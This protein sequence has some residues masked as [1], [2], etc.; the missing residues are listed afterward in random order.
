MIQNKFNDVTL[1]TVMY[2][3]NFIIENFLRN[4]FFFKKILILDN[5][6]S[7]KNKIKIN[8]KFKNVKYFISKN[9][10]G[11]ARGNNFLL[12][13]VTT[14]YVFIAT[15][16]L[17]IDKKN[18]EILYDSKK[19]IKSFG[20][21]APYNIEKSYIKIK[22]KKTN[23][24]KNIFET[25]RPDGFAL[26]IDMSN[27]RKVKFFDE[28]FF[29]FFEDWDLFNRFIKK[30]YKLYIIKNSK[31]FHK[32]GLSSCVS[33][34]LKI[35]DFHYGWSFFYYYKKNY[36]NL[37]SF[38]NSIFLTIKV[39]FNFLFLKKNKFNMVKGLIDSA[40]I[41]RNKDF[42]RDKY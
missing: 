4:Y 6:G 26:F 1:V 12:K 2:K 30:N 23:I 24:N 38:I 11:F 20:I 42:Y 5:S 33:N 22:I 29:L 18:F 21:L 32:I 34:I 3:S 40:F 41:N 17:M 15:P 31:I 14:D 8:K 13:K 9:N 7:I 25:K 10:L 37:I 27:F 36:G 39:V 19:K 28:N 16:D 35:R